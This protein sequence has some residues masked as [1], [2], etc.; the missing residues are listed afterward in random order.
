MNR[1]IPTTFMPVLCLI[2]CL[3]FS[4]AASAADSLD[5]NQ[6]IPILR[7]GIIAEENFPFVYEGKH[8]QWQGFE[9]ELLKKLQHKLNIDQL[10]LWTYP[11][12]DALGHCPA[13]E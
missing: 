2:L 3:A 5:L 11:D 1:L 13:E 4:P 6:T 8:G 10:Q 12:H 7:A 9:I